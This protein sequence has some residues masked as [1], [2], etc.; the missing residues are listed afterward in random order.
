MQRLPRAQRWQ[1]LPR[2]TAALA[3]APETRSLPTAVSRH[4]SSPSLRQ[5]PEAVP[6]LAAAPVACPPCCAAVV[7]GKCPSRCWCHGQ[8]P[9]AAAG[10]VDGVAALGLATATGG[11]EGGGGLCCPGDARFGAVELSLIAATAISARSFS[12]ACCGAAAITL[13]PQEDSGTSAG[14]A[15][16]PPSGL[17]P[18]VG[19]HVPLS[20]LASSARRAAGAAAALLPHRTQARR[21]GLPLRRPPLPCSM[22]APRAALPVPASATRQTPATTTTTPAAVPPGFVP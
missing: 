15:G 9:R 3:L 1:V 16:E 4:G 13:A 7:A 11:S 21:R 22:G 10:T 20:A 2:T 6:T 14:F 18:W 8:T 12:T 17:G 19:Y 5:L